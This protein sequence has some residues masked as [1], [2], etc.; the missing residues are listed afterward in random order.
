MYEQISRNK[1]RTVLIILG[2]LV[3]VGGLGYLFGL[4]LGTGP[5]GLV[6]AVLIAEFMLR[7]FWWGGGAFGGRGRRSDGGEGGNTFA[8][9]AGYVLILAWII[10]L[11]VVAWWAKES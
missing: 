6:V 5:V 10:W 8:I 11:V 7:W 3:V 2:T 1:R 4:L 9:L